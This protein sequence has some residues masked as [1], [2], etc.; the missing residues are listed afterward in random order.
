[1]QEHIFRII[2]W[3]SL[4]GYVFFCLSWNL[5]FQSRTVTDS[6]HWLQAPETKVAT[7]L[8]TRTENLKKETWKSLEKQ[9]WVGRWKRIGLQIRI[10]SGKEKVSVEL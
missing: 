3:A 8:A 9:K 6:R 10:K 2:F 5:A 7:D 4:V 1:M